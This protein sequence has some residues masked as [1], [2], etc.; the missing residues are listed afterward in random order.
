MSV[1]TWCQEHLCWLSPWN[2]WPFQEP[3][4]EVP[5]PY[6]RPIFQAYVREYPH[7]IWPTIWY[8]TS[9]LGSWNSHWLNIHNIHRLAMEPILPIWRTLNRSR[10]LPE[11][12]MASIAHFFRGRDTMLWPELLPGRRP[13]IKKWW[14]W[15][16]LN[17]QKREYHQQN[18]EYY[19]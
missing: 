6:I 7:K 12:A 14:C 16:S 13:T 2:Q 4:L 8:S 11:G 3:K 19:I 17:H 10:F 5:I 9:I 1:C 18:R 15:T